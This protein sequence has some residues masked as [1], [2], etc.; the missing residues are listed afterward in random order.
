MIIGVSIIWLVFVV[1]FF[2]LGLYHWNVAKTKVP[3]FKLRER[4]GKDMGSVTFLGAD[5][6]QPLKDFVDE[7]NEHLTNQNE[8][9]KKQN[10]CSAY[11]YWLAAL[12]ALVSLFL[13]VKN[14]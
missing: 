3:P 7:F 1:L 14:Y 11:G 10:R 9:S 5:I 8:L 13:V 2:K 6:D 4:P 12:T